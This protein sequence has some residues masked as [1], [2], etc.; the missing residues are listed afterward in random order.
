M[1][2]LQ[3]VP[4]DMRAELQKFDHE[5][6]DIIA[7]FVG[8]LEASPPPSIIYHYTDDVGLRGILET[9]CI[10]LTDIFNLNDPSELSHGFSQVVNIMNSKAFHG[11]PPSKLF[12]QQV[13][14]F[15]TQGGIGAAAHY[16]VGSFSSTGDDLGQWRAYADNGRGYALGFDA[17]ELEKAFTKEG[18]VPI[19]NNCTFPVTYNDGKLVELN[20]QLIER[21]FPLLSLP[22]G[23]GLSSEGIREYTNELFELFSVHALRSVLFFQA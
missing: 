16:F 2:D 11:P 23:R 15:L 6:D 14:A 5:A 21:A 22:Y 10:W 18:D 1:S 7:S 19:P 20:V 9:G 17:K 12:A 4:P 3:S 8:T 13:E